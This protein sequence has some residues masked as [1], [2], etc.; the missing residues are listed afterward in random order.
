MLYSDRNTPH[1]AHGYI[2]FAYIFNDLNKYF[3]GP[4]DLEIPIQPRNENPIYLFTSGRRQM[5]M[6]RKAKTKIKMLR[7]VGES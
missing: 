2:R 6:L 1:E 7:L 4:S 5:K 3:R